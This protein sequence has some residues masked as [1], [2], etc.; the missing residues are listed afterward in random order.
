[1]V[2][3]DRAPRDHRDE[4]EQ[5]NNGGPYGNLPLPPHLQPG[6]Q[7]G[8]QFGY[9]LQGLMIRSCRYSKVLDT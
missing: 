2:R 3:D 1:M 6:Q 7:L 5:V 8:A 4:P 9:Q